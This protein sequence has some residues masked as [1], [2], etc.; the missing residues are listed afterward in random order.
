MSQCCTCLSQL[1]LHAFHHKKASRGF[2]HLHL[3]QTLY[4]TVT[5][6]TNTCTHTMSLSEML[7]CFQIITSYCHFC[8]KTICPCFLLS[9]KLHRSS[10]V[11]VRENELSC[12]TSPSSLP[13]C[14]FPIRTWS[15]NYKTKLLYLLWRMYTTLRFCKEV[16]WVCGFDKLTIIWSVALKI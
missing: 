12:S 15:K 2:I 10:I 13:H 1:C 6:V 8:A 9:L 4:L 3:L 14:M 5:V 11:L 16:H 7:F